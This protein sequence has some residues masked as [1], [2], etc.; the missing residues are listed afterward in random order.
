M[1][2]IGQGGAGKVFRINENTAEK[3]VHLKNQCNFET[4]QF[5]TNNI[6]KLKHKSI[7][8]VRSVEFINNQATIQWDY[9]DGIT[10]EKYT[11]N[12]CKLSTQQIDSIYNAIEYLSTIDVIHGDIT[13]NNILLTQKNEIKI[14]DFRLLDSNRQDLTCY[15]NNDKQNVK[16][17]II[18]ERQ[19]T[20]AIIENNSIYMGNV[21]RRQDTRDS[22]ILDKNYD[23]DSFEKLRLKLAI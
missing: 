8:D 12:G 9:I 15:L 6:L 1:E 2:Q 4:E 19:I 13:S 7:Y 18:Y 22:N 20:R 10:L 11:N 3:T 5:I 16:R 14:I 21:T 17:R 23:F